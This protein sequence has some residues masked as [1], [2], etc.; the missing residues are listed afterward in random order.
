MQRTNL[1]ATIIAAT[2]IVRA[3]ADHNDIS[4]E[5]FNIAAT[6]TEVAEF[7]YQVAN[8]VAEGHSPDAPEVVQFFQWSVMKLVELN[9]MMPEP[10][11]ADLSFECFMRD[12]AVRTEGSGTTS[13]GAH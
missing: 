3:V 10:E 5:N 4:I 11:R 2:D 6:A 13:T 12:R 7:A 9:G 1:N 8:L